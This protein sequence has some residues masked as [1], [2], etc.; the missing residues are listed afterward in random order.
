MHTLLSAQSIA[1]TQALLPAQLV[2]S[3]RQ[4]LQAHRSKGLRAV[5]MQKSEGEPVN[6]AGGQYQNWEAQLPSPQL[7]AS[8]AQP[9]LPFV[10]EYAE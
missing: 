7:L 4:A 6:P 5:C 8:G 9:H 1:L 10:H 3:T 2:T